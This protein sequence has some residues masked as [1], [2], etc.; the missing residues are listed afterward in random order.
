MPWR[1]HKPEEIVAKLRQIDVMVA[2]VNR[3]TT[4]ATHAWAAKRRG[5]T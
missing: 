4:T 1:R 2:Q 3:L 5:A